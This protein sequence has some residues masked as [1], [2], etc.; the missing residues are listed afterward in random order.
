MRSTGRLADKV[1]IITGGSSGLGKATAELF[2][3]EGAH[4]V[5]ADVSV[6]AGEA[7]ADSIAARFEQTDVS[8]EQ[9]VE[10]L[11]R[12]VTNEFGRLD[13]I[14]NNAGVT[15]EPKPVGETSTEDFQR[16]VSVNFGGVFFGLRA[17]ARVMT[18]QGFGSIVN[19]A[20]I[21][22]S[23]PT[24]GI[25]V[26]CATKA[27]VIAL[28]RAAAVELAPQRVRVN[29]VSPGAM[30]TGMVPDDPAVISALDRLQPVGYAAGPRL[31][32][33]GVVF[34]ASDEAEFVTGHDLVIDGG[35][36]A[37]RPTVE[38]RPL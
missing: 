10:K 28:T 38:R 18:A 11:I 29:S 9:E 5:I 26:Y 31:I 8:N 17:A 13:I 34:L 12:T 25:A 20:S 7:V 35:A 21:G 1:S 16:L 32:G 30:L 27:A 33:H 6:S 37:G 36:T 3:G 14:V 19:V 15:S 22:G 4:V 23:T 24:A 2:A